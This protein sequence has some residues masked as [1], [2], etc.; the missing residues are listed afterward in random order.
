MPTSAAPWQCSPP[1]RVTWKAGRSATP[2]GIAA[3][4]AAGC[5][6]YDLLQHLVDA[7]QEVAGK[8]KPEGL[9]G[10]EIHDELDLV[11]LHHGQVRGP[12]ALQHAR[13]VDAGLAVDVA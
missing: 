9:R 8:R 1:S 13:R 6:R 7:R 5:K 2:S 3:F 11:H 10:L 4:P 12:R